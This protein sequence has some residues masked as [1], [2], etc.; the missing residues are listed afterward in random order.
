[1][2]ELRPGAFFA[3]LRVEAMIGRG[4]MGIV[5]RA[6]QLDLE[7]VV[8]LKV[9]AP[10]LLEHA[11]A[12]A[13]FLREARAAAS[14][15]HPNVIPVYSAGEQDGIAYLTMR[16]VN[17]DDVRSLVRRAGPLLPTR[18][19][20]IT[21]QAG[22]ALDAV[23]AAGL[24]HRDVKP[25]N[26]L[27]GPDDHVYVTDFGLAKSALTQAGET[28][29]G[30]WVG[31]LDYVSPEQIRG[32][33]VD[34]RADVY[35]LGG[36]LHF[37]LTSKAP[38]PRGD[39]EARLWAHLSD[40]PPKPS[41]E[42]A[43]AAFDEIVARAM[44]KAPSH[45]YP[46][47]GDLGRAAIAV[48]IGRPVGEPER[49]VARGAA[50]LGE[51][52]DDDDLQVTEADADTVS[53][54]RRQV[55]ATETPGRLA[56]P[57]EGSEARRRRPRTLAIL[58]AALGVFAGMGAATALLRDDEREPASPVAS[59]V[60]DIS[61][62]VNVFKAAGERPNGV[63]L[64][65]DLAWVTTFTSRRV[66]ALDRSTGRVRRRVT[67][68]EGASDIVAAGGD[69]Y[70][71]ATRAG[72]VVRLDAHTGQVR[73][74][75]PVRKPVAIAVDGDALWVG[76][77]TATRGQ[78]DEVIR[79]EPRRLRETTR[80]P[81]PFGV[82]TLALTDDRLW[83]GHRRSERVTTLD[84]STG[85]QTLL[86]RSTGTGRVVDMTVDRRYVWVSKEEGVLARVDRESGSVATIAT[87]GR[88]GQIALAGGRVWVALVDAGE[89][90]AIDITTSRRVGEN[91]PVGLNPFGVA[92][93][94]SA[95]FVTSRGDGTVTR[96]AY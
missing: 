34:A 2:G 79:F 46:S 84:R 82:A 55:A 47:A 73:A 8:A 48:A 85:R 91:I 41:L 12:R 69:L 27:L 3:G 24:I 58:L 45:R 71:A 92:A 32:G 49:G 23:H 9:I 33:Q 42:G 81:V 61:P 76:S 44:A 83:I 59:P 35:A 20:S 57:I 65:E 89:L 4:G 31:T 94:E 38:F 96:V 5:Y 25:A 53:A 74:T 22:A 18:A 7:R 36:V 80:M 50:A 43:P 19:A 26:V 15:D 1:M 16:F 78:P 13:R 51:E 88:A 29:S 70:I 67:I 63:A 72:R 37:M 17:G 75:L 14:I 77:R 11:A 60:P 68:G 30:Q 21:A 28:R 10:E 64:T 52:G 86:S 87:G 6:R 93:D 54:T 39:D 95:V 66:R 90:V 56:E 62:E 40:P